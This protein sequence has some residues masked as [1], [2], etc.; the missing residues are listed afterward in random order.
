MKQI[1]A[2]RGELG[3]TVLGL[4]KAIATDEGKLPL[5]EIHRSTLEAMGTHLFH[6]DV[7]A[8]ALEGT[9]ARHDRI[10]DAALRA[11]PKSRV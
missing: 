7:E 1:T 2:V 8:E 3:H 4:M 6:Q 10:D 11:D 5:H 9:F